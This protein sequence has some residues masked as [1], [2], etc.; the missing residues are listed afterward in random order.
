[1]TDKIN[2]RTPEEIKKGLECCCIDDCNMC[3][4]EENCFSEDEELCES[5]VA[6]AI[7][8]IQQLEAAQPKWISV[9]E[10]LPEENFEV[11]MLFKHN[12]A[13]GFYDG[14]GEWCANTD[15]GYHAYCDGTPTHWMP[16][17]EW[18]EEG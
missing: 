11:L 17:P 6:D 5:M 16:L 1:M 7:A 8:L 15:D 13:V 18:P 12:M 3:T 2:G 9:E 4:Y 10:R 14:D